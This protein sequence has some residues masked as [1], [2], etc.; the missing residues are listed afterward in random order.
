MPPR[1]VDGLRSIIT[2]S[3]VK[4]WI[5]LPEVFLLTIDPDVL[6]HASHLL[7]ATGATIERPE[8]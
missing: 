5:R 7:S 2:D 6:A 1:S 3:V 4:P 8:S